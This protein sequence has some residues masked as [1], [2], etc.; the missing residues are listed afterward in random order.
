MASFFES[1]ANL[2]ALATFV[3]VGAVG[4]MFAHAFARR[5]D[6]AASLKRRL[7]LAATRQGEDVAGENDLAAIDNDVFGDGDDDRSGEGR[8]AVL[9]EKIDLKL[10]LIGGIGVLRKAIPIAAGVGLLAMIVGIAKL[11]LPLTYGLA[12]GFIVFAGGLVLGLRM[13]LQRTYQKFSDLFPDAIDLVVRSIRA[14][15]PVSQALENI[16]TD[17]E[18]P[19]GPEFARIANEMRIGVS[20]DDSLRDALFR[21]DLPE[22]RFFAVTLILQRETGGQLAEVL[23]NLSDMLRQR[24]AMKLKIKA[25]TSESRAA[26]KI[27]AAIPCFSA[28]GM[29]YLNKPHVMLLVEE[30][31]GQNMLIYCV[32]SITIGMLIIKKLTAVDA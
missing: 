23:L 14:G 15:L 29:Y 17:I 4:A 27:V 5:G 20:L 7:K 18:A 31:V 19:V 24:K 25:L 3:L 22:M 32:V 2:I 10:A 21:I 9:R 12:F 28:L 1:D 8:L 16:G 30:P 6:R 13:A 11:E 26:S